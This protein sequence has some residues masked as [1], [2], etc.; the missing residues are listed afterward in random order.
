M[1]RSVGAG[2][3]P[4]WRARRPP[5]RRAGQ[6]LAVAVRY[7]TPVQTS[8]VVEA[9]T[10][11][12]PDELTD[13]QPA[14]ASAPPGPGRSPRQPG[15]WPA[16]LTEGPLWTLWM[17]NIVSAIVTLAAGLALLRDARRMWFSGDEWDFLL[18]RD[19]GHNTL[20]HLFKPHN[21]HWT[22]LPIIAFRIVYS[23]FGTRTYLP[24]GAMAILCHLLA[25]LALWSVL[26]R[27]GTPPWVVTA[28][29]AV[30][31]FLGAGAENTLWDFQICFIGA[32]L[33]GL[34][35][36]RIA[37]ADRGRLGTV[38]GVW[39]ALLASLMCSG[40]GIPMVILCFFYFVLAVSLRR[41]L[42]AISVPAF[43]YIVWYFSVGHVGTNQSHTTTTQYLTV[44][45][46]VTSGLTHIWDTI[47]DVSG[48][49]LV[50]LV[51]LALIPFLGRRVGLLNPVA[52]AGMA[53]VVCMYALIALP[54]VQLGVGA[55]LA[56][57]YVYVGAVLMFPALALLLATVLARAQRFNVVFHGLVTVAVALIVI[58]G[59]Q[60]NQVYTNVM[61]GPQAQ[62][63]AATIGA[64]SILKTNAK[65][66]S[67]FP[68]PITIP[69]LSTDQL[70]G[71]RPWC[72]LRR[73]WP[74]RRRR[75]DLVADP[76]NGHRHHPYPRRIGEPDSA[77][78]L[79]AQSA[80]LHRD[81]CFRCHPAHLP[82]RRSHPALS[83]RLNRAFSRRGCR[84]AT[85]PH[86]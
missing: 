44:P 64:V 10:G 35:A 52:A 38:L 2:R 51:V 30:F 39:A 85:R 80:N 84:P 49:G 74:L 34:V 9:T 45:H 12:A 23:I 3:T 57:R 56:G 76:D 41:A 59:V 31:A 5:Q 17:P 15:E 66:L 37:V 71:D 48:A 25:V 11:E 68:D 61:V 13:E 67:K 77:L 29:V 81:L 36:M 16:S 32:V 79:R 8:P 18:G 24:Y 86:R 40:M 21:E 70:D 60:Q 65:I 42:A 55:A 46:F 69:P 50:M 20:A 82:T 27:V 58:T 26:R 75:D 6:H 72:A 14:V 22:T 1:V 47:I 43:A 28:V 53:A 4:R 73:P 33:F 7:R 54:R 78:A 19:L 62:T 83:R 63:K